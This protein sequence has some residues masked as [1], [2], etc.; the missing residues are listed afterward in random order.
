MKV[1]THNIESLP[2]WAQQ[3]ISRLNANVE[4][5]KRLALP[6]TVGESNTKVITYGVEGDISL[7]NSSKVRFIMEG[8]G[9]GRDYIEAYVHTS[10][11]DGEPSTLMVY[12]GDSLSIIPRASNSVDIVANR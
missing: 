11:I 9:N 3:E 4:Y 12:G 10:D 7:P 2:K 6:V 5:W 1:Q 8:M